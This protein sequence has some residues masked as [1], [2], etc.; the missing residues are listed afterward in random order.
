MATTYLDAGKKPGSKQRQDG[1]TDDEAG[2]PAADQRQGNLPTNDP[3]PFDDDDS[4]I[5][6]FGKVGEF[7]EEQK[8]Q[9][10]EKDG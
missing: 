3:D 6:P 2:V 4:K 9:N 8:K 1:L 5:P 10:V 7:A